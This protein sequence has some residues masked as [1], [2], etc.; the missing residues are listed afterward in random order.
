MAPVE[1]I[2]NTIENTAASLS[3]DDGFLVFAKNT[4]EGVGD[5]TDGGVGLDGREDRREKV[6][7]CS[8]AALEF[9]ECEI[10]PRGITLRAQSVQAGDLRSLDVF[11]H[12]QRGDTAFL[13]RNKLIYPRDDLFFCFHRAL[14][15]ISR[16]LNLALN[17]PRFNR[18][19]R[20]S[21]LV[22]LRNVKPRE[23]F[24]LVGERFD[25]V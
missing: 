25:G 6:L 15:I 20:P 5:F 17:K 9:G 12:A 8:G 18:A 19:Q 1:M 14:E 7:R 11:I 10:D 13:F 23:R 21:H 3:N 16:L 22:D 24:D 4:A 2:K